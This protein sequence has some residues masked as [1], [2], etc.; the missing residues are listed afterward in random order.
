MKA[1]ALSLVI[2]S[3]LALWAFYIDRSA[4]GTPSTPSAQPAAA[5]PATAQPATVRPAT[6]QP[7]TAQPAATQPLPDPRAKDAEPL[8][9]APKLDPKNT[10]HPLNAQKTFLWELAPAA[11]PNEKPKPVR[12]LFVTEVC[13][14]EGPLEVFLC[15]KGT[16][17]HEAILRV[18]LDAKLIHAAL[19]ASG[20]KVGTPTQFVNPK[21][22]EPEFKP[23]TGNKIKVTVHYRKGGKLHTHPAQ[24]WVWNSMK[25]KSLDADWVFA[26]SQEIRDPD[27]PKAEPFYGANSGEVITISNFPYSMLD[28][29]IEVSKDDANLNYEAKTDRIPPLFSKVWVILEPVPNK[30]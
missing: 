11:A 20:A 8:P 17:E 5:Q 3:A 6:T 25:K 16:K 21:T 15:K 14:R 27:N 19:L 22:N 13:L 23:A 30:K 7:V 18:D 29:P 4:H 12:L 1:I 24:E 2:A 26:G 10:H 28:L 9:E